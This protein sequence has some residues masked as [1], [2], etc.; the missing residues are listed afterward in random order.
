M[1]FQVVAKLSNKESLCICEITDREAELAKQDAPFVDGFGL[2]LV[3]VDA[4]NPKGIGTILAKFSSET[5]AK[6]L[7]QMF[8]QTG[9]FEF[10]A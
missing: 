5:A 4:D 10:A 6:K 2:Y 8:V 3:S 9:R 7:A 1:A